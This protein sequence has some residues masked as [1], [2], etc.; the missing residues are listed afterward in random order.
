MIII[1]LGVFLGGLTEL[2]QLY[3]PK[4]SAGIDDFLADTIG[5]LFGAFLLILLKKELFLIEK[6]FEK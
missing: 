3:I 4:R 5:V 1:L 6:K 2:A